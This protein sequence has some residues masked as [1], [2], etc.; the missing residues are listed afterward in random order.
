MVAAVSA[1]HDPDDLGRRTAA[2]LLGLATWTH[3][4]HLPGWQEQTSQILDL[5]QEALPPAP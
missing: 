4:Q 2:V 1:P 3:S 5:V